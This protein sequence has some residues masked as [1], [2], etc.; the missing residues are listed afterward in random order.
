MSEKHGILVRL[1]GLAHIL[2]NI[3]NAR[4]AQLARVS[5]C[6]GEGRGFESRLSLIIMDPLGS[7]IMSDEAW[8]RIHVLPSSEYG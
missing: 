1:Q 6:Q 4:V 5:P 2:S 3:K 8:R 7:L